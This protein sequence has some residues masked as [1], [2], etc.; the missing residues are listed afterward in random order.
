VSLNKI[1]FSYKYVITAHHKNSI[2]LKIKGREGTVTVWAAQLQI[3]FAWRGCSPGQRNVSN[4]FLV[5]EKE[6]QQ[7]ERIL[8]QHKRRGYSAKP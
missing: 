6:S 7:K 4:S 3:E 5:N 8:L 1:L 2:P